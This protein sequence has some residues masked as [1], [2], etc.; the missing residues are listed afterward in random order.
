MCL[1]R[2][3]LWNFLLS[4][5]KDKDIFKQLLSITMNYP[6]IRNRRDKIK[7]KERE[8]ETKTVCWHI[9][10]F[11]IF[12]FFPFNLLASWQETTYLPLFCYTILLPIIYYRR[13]DKKSHFKRAIHARATHITTHK[14]EIC[15][16][17]NNTSV[18]LLS[19]FDL[20]PSVYSRSIYSF[21]LR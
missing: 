4:L 5:H 12:C 8:R 15:L 2:C 21:V 10:G 14:R 6:H 17:E 18:G 16:L 13:L 9:D 20:W 7:E 19:T 11:C 3:V 1:C